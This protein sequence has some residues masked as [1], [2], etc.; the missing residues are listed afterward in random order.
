MGCVLLVRLVVKND[1]LLLA[2]TALVRLSWVDPPRER[3]H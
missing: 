2:L 1:V 3:A